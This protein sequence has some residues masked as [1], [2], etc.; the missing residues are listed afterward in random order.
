MVIFF[1]LTSMFPPSLNDGDVWICSLRSGKR[2]SRKDGR[3][4]HQRLKA[5]KASVIPPKGLI[6]AEGS[7]IP[8]DGLARKTRLQKQAQI[9]RG[10]D[11]GMAEPSVPE[12][13]MAEEHAKGEEEAL[14][15]FR[16]AENDQSEGASESSTHACPCGKVYSSNDTLMSHRANNTCVGGIP[17]VQRGLPTPDASSTNPDVNLRRSGR[18]SLK[19]PIVEV[20]LDEAEIPQA[21]SSASSKKRGRKNAGPGQPKS[22][23]K[24]RARKLM[25]KVPSALD[26]DELESEDETLIGGVSSSARSPA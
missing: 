13:E 9:K 8:K 16:N 4:R 19:R 11:E 6:T 5:C 7:E 21:H 12:A 1:L 18:V 15:A 25:V 26:D 14:Q 24:H 2:F 10:R 23:I 3:I 17:P 20:D 22:E